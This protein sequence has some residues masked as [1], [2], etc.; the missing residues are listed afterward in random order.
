[1]TGGITHVFQVI[2]LATSAYAALGAGSPTV[3]PGFQAEE[4]FLELDHTCIGKQ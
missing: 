1:M 2:V 3:G 4:G